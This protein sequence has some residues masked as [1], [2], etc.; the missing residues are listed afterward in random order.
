M[1]YFCVKTSEYLADVLDR[2]SRG[3]EYFLQLDVPQ[4]KAYTIVEK[5]TERYKL[6]QTARQRTYR[7]KSAPV[8]DLVVLQNMALFQLKQ[9]RL[10]LL[11]TF[12]LPERL[13]ELKTAKNRISEVY[14]GKGEQEQFCSVY[15]RKN[16]L[17]LDVISPTYELV[18]LP[19]TKK[20]R[21]QKE[22]TK[23][24]GWTWRLHEDF[25]KFRLEQIE[26]NYQQ[27]QRYKDPQKQDAYIL[28][29][30]S[31]LWRMAGFRGVRDNIFKMNHKLNGLSFRYLN[32]KN[33]VEM[34]IP[35][36]TIKTKR[37]VTDFNGMREFHEKN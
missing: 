31:K 9:V 20:E 15:D 5:W 14:L 24:K 34:E 33:S 1:I 35:R 12:P 7:L 13:N 3:A 17:I 19:Y 2:V 28:K 30:L 18:E 22:I 21:K 6:D 32:R 36:Y 16:R 4:D 37:T 8:L 23:E 27:A 10:C 11:A 29:D 25:I 26:T